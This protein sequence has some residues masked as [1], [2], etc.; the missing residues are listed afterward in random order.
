[1]VWTRD[2]SSQGG[3]VPHTQVPPP[4]GEPNFGV[5]VVDWGGLLP[6]KCQKWLKIPLPPAA[7]KDRD[8]MALQMAHTL[9]D[10]LC[11]G[12]CVQVWRGCK[13]PGRD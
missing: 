3:V 13:R 5:K 6:Q 1:M 9:L 11:A 7:D 8:K 12:E 2:L 10:R 4:P